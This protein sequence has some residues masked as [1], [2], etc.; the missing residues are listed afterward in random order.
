MVYFCIFMYARI[1]DKERRTNASL[2]VGYSKPTVKGI[3]CGF[4]Y[5]CVDTY[6][7][8]RDSFAFGM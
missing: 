7:D 3:A 5:N 6:T 4:F 8:Q 2:P 1:S